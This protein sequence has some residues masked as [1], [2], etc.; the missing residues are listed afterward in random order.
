MNEEITNIMESINPNTFKC[1]YS[2]NGMTLLTSE[3]YGNRLNQI[4]KLKQENQQLKEENQML[5]LTIE[6]LTKTPYVYEIRGV[7]ND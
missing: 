5:K 1:V 4:H 2:V 7:N 6:K 3:E